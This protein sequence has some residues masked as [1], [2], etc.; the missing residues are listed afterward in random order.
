TTSSFSL[1]RW[2]QFPTVRYTRWFFLDQQSFYKPGEKT[3]LT[4]PLW[5]HITRT[6]E[7][8]QLLKTASI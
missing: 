3:A 5:Y 6:A 8:R 4:R 1:T 7:S 2:V